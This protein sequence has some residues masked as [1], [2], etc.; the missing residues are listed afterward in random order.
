MDYTYQTVTRVASTLNQPSRVVVTR[1]TGGTRVT[2]GNWTF[3][4][5]QGADQDTTVVACECGKTTYRYAGIGTAGPFNAWTSGVLLERTVSEPGPSGAQLEREVL[6]YQQSLPISNSP[7]PGQSGVWADPAVYQALVSRRQI[8][9]GTANWITDFHY[10]TVLYNDFGRPWRIHVQGDQ[11]LTTDRTF[12]YAFTPWIVDRIATEKVKQGV[13]ERNSSWSYDDTTGFMTQSNA[14][15]F[16]TNYTPNAFGQVA[17]V[18]NANSHTTSFTYEWGVLKN[19]TTPLLTTGRVINQDGTVASETLGS[20]L[21]TSYVYDLAFRLR[22]VRPPAYPTVN[23]IVY[24]YDDVTSY[25][26]RTARGSAQTEQ[27]L[28]GFGRAMSTSTNAGVK[29]RVERDQCGRVTYASAPYTTGPGNRGTATTYDAL[30]RVKIVTGPG[31]TPSVTTYAYTGADVTITDAENHAT[32]YDYD[33]FS[34]PGDAR[35]M[36]VTD[37]TNTQTNYQYDVIGN[38]TNVNGP[39]PVPQRSWVYNLRGELQSDTQPESGTTSYVYDPVGNLTSLTNAAGTTTF[40]YDANERLTGRD[41]PGTASDVTIVY[42]THGRVQTQSIDGVATTF[43]YDTAGRPQSRTDGIHPAMVFSSSYGYD[44]NDNLT[45]MTYPNGRQVIYSYDTAFRLTGVQYNGNPFAGTFVYDG[46]GRL[47]SYYTGAVG[48]T[49]L[50]DDKDRV[51][52]IAAGPGIGH[53]RLLYGYDKVHN[54]TS[55]TDQRVGSPQTVQ[56][57]TYDVLDRMQTAT[58]PWGGISWTY[59]SA[60]NRLTEARG[61]TTVYNYSGTTNRLTHTTGANPE[62]FTWTGLGQLQTNTRGANTTTYT[63][64]PAGMLLTASAP[65]VSASYLY[66]AD[67]LRVKRQVNGRTYVTVRG[68]GGQV[69]AEYETCGGPVA[70][71]RDNVYAGARLLGAARANV[72]LPTISFTSPTLNAQENAGN[73]NVGVQLVT[74]NGA[75]LTCE[76]TVTFTLAPGTAAPLNDYTP[77]TATVTFAMGTASGTVI[78]RQIAIIEDTF[79]EVDETLTATLSG[80]SGAL[81][82]ATTAVTTTIL[83]NDATPTMTVSSPIVNEA[84]GVAQFQVNLSAFSGKQVTVNYAT[85]NGLAVACTGGNTAICDYTTTSGTLTL[86]PMTPTANINVP[87]YNNTRAEL[88]ETFYLNL[89]GAVNATLNTTQAIASINDDE[90]RAPIDQSMPIYVFSDVQSSAN[91]SGYLQLYNQYSTSLLTRVTLTRDDG[92]G[93]TYFYTVP[94]LQ[95]L[96]VDLQTQA[97]MN[98][99]GNFTLSVQST[100]PARSVIMSELSSYTPGFAGGRN[101]IASG[102]GT[103]LYFAEGS[104]SGFFDEYLTLVNTGNAAVDVTVKFIPTFGSPITQVYRINEGP[105]RIR[106]RLYDILG[107]YGDHSTIV[108]GTSVATGLPTNISAERSTL[109]PTGGTPIETASVMSRAILSNDYYFAEGG[110]GFWSTYLSV[111]NPSTTSA[112][113]ISVAYLHDNGSTYT[114]TATVAANGRT[115]LSPPSTMPDGGFGL[116]VTSTNGVPITTDRAMYGGSGWTL[117]HAT[118]GAPAP[119]NRWLFS[120]GVSNNFFDT[121]FLIANPNTT[122]STITIT[123]RRTDGVAFTPAAMTVPARGRLVVAADWIT[124]VSGYTYAAEVISTNGVGVVAERAMYWPDGSWSGAHVTV[125]RPQ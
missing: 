100:D 33:A 64:S 111:L 80:P 11:S 40:S 96:D 18:T 58:G 1:A 81:L 56:S 101:E 30:G 107:A 122:A 21:T 28:D 119:A 109:W 115:V 19:T 45:S 61:G 79:D 82:G 52:E 49:T 13:N 65:G 123:F 37:A 3:T 24:E 43:A 25:F 16:V 53:L 32:T 83:D 105:G 93:A 94:A 15:G 78:N 9:R 113:N 108:S 76:A 71:S 120:E 67:H 68:F 85:S 110:K 29:T 34:G 51:S 73:V 102:V 70:W 57:Y 91:E 103:I 117:G 55:I 66:D 72:A 60:G 118:R 104:V 88:P 41:A 46:S 10:D 39:G 20:S 31:T 124:G 98:G 116:H 17:S 97:G 75:P 77:Q 74:A 125:G 14:V 112:S 92:T 99:T 36:R 106:L 90:V 86:P 59:D 50:Y 47:Q 48:H 7:V 63:Y 121:Y 35:L 89:S 26:V 95:R 42:D 22:K 69:L 8:W 54:V 114:Q 4:Y 2:P 12:D 6:T 87:L 84:T 23:E 5:N 27:L 62:T 38:L 44:A